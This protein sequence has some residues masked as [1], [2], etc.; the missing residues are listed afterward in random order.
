MSIPFVA[1]GRSAGALPERPS[2]LQ[3]RFDSLKD[4][5]QQP[6][7]SWPSSAQHFILLSCYR[8]KLLL[9]AK[10]GPR[11][12]GLPLVLLVLVKLLLE[13]QG[14]P[15]TSPREPTDRPRR[16]HRQAQGVPQGSPTQAGAPAPQAS[17]G[18]RTGR[19]RRSHLAIPIPN[20]TATNLDRAIGVPAPGGGR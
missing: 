2:W 8:S 13:A 18:G 1:P 17:P 10:G 14:V 16:S 11:P 9:E 3:E 19:T 15:Q 20:R 4:A 12:T 7:A 5:V 6:Q